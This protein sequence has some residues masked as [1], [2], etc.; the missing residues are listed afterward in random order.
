MPF[1][2]F[3]RDAKK[4]INSPAMMGEF[5]FGVPIHTMHRMRRDYLAQFEDENEEDLEE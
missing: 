5:M 4:T 3:Y 2:R 1:G